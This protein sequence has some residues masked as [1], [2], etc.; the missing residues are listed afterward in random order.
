MES[1]LS[2]DHE[3][4]VMNLEDA[5]LEHLTVGKFYIFICSSYGD[6]DLPESAI[7]F[8]DMIEAEKPN[9]SV[10]KFSIF[11]LGDTDCK[12]TYNNG[13]Q[14]LM[15]LLIACCSQLHGPRGLLH[16]ASSMEPSE[17]SALPWEQAR[18]TELS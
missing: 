11:G 2:S 6:G 12:K 7:D 17:D 5:A 18:L 14:R 16:Y 4:V 10:V 13:S 15:G 8:G 9:L 1:K 3:V